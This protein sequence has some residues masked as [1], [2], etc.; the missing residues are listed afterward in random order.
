MQCWRKTN[1]SVLSPPLLHHDDR[2]HGSW[3]HGKVE[4]YLLFFFAHHNAAL[5]CTPAS[6]LPPTTI[7]AGVEANK[8][9]QSG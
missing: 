2:A 8:A 9:C 5:Q 6:R 1:V 3:M 7:I 4:S